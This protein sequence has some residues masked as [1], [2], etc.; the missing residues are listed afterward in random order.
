MQR[1]HR[2]GTREHRK[3][4]FASLRQRPDDGLAHRVDVAG[5][6]GDDPADLGAVEV[7]HAQSLQVAED[8][9]RRSKTMR[10]PIET[11]RQI[12]SRQPNMIRHRRHDQ[13]DHVEGQAP[14]VVLPGCRR[15]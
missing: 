10:L 14:H 4:T 7:R 8:V 1:H 13:D 5:A 6:A 3:A 9:L 11:T 2:Q 12:T 15:R